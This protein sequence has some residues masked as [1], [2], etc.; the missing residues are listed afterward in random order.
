MSFCIPKF[1][2]LAIKKALKSGEIQLGDLAK[3]TSAGRR[4]VFEQ[5][6]DNVTAKKINTEFEKAYAKKQSEAIKKWIKKTVSPKDRKK[7]F[8]KSA[9]EKADS[10]IELGVINPD[11]S[12]AFMEDLTRR[13]LGVDVTAEEVM[14]IKKLGDDLIQKQDDFNEL[15]VPKIEY[16]KALRDMQEYLQKKRPASKLKVATSVIGRGMMLFSLKSPVMNV[17]STG[18]HGLVT[19]FER[20]LSNLKINGTNSDLATEYVKYA[21]K[22]YQETGFD[23]SRMKSVNDTRTILGEEIIHSQGEGKTRRAGR[24]MESVV[25]KQLMGAPDVAFSSMHF[26]DSVNIGSAKLAQ[27]EGLD[28]ETL[29]KR[30]R[31]MMADAMSMEPK[32]LEGQALRE[33]AINDAEYSTFTQ[34]G[35][36]SKFSMGAR[37]LLNDMSGDVRWGDLVVPFAKTPANVIETSIMTAGFGFA[38]SAV[39][40]RTALQ[41]AADATTP[42]QK[43][44]ARMYMQK[45]VIRPSVA[46]GF[47]LILA[48]LI[49]QAISPDDFMG[50]YPTSAKDRALMELERAKPNSIKIGNKWINLDYF[51]PLAAPLVGMLYA[52]KYGDSLPDQ[53][54]R[55]SRGFYTQVTKIPGFDALNET[56]G[57]IKNVR[58]ESDTDLK[59][60]G[61]DI[62][63]N[64]V[65]FIAARTIPALVYDVAK[66]TDPYDRQVGYDVPI[67]PLLK[68]IPFARKTLPI[69]KD[70]LGFPVERENPVAVILFGSRYS[71]AN[72]NLIVR[73]MKKLQRRDQLPSITKPYTSSRARAFEDQVPKQTYRRFEN[74]YALQLRDALAKEIRSRGYENEKSAEKRKRRLEKVKGDVLDK[75]LKDFGYE[76]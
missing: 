54:V 59:G 31:E 44:A 23:I 28:G 4:K 61:K 41:K 62:A 10:L 9:L 69:K 13:T 32:T 26:A 74:S 15:G 37:K 58:P 73:E 71:T 47:G 48:F 56:L 66:A 45:N 65:D 63:K 5:Y 29:N 68:R 16:F 30:S 50:E 60:F 52:R 57:M 76:K 53:M 38:K 7:P 22:V 64:A 75:A 8:Y 1:A 70:V 67:D 6:T 49:S 34:D 51:G 33:Q 21:N 39:H 35:N 12:D 20:R 43:L 40:L 2:S 11:T 14:E 55:Y 17:V 19:S 72:S 36:M 46:S 18:T 42:T 27:L 24:F 25:F 3:N